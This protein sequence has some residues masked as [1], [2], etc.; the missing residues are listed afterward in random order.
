MKYACVRLPQA[1]QYNHHRHRDRN[2]QIDW[3]RKAECLN[4]NFACKF[5]EHIAQPRTDD[6]QDGGPNND[7]TLNG[8][9]LCQLIR[10]L[11]IAIA[12]N[13]VILKLKFI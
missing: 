7:R 2:G 4:L 6:V 8:Y 12:E 11:V 13:R 9:A 1:T 5:R 10:L 3:E